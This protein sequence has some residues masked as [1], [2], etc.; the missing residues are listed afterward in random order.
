METPVKIGFA[1][2]ILIAFAIS[3]KVLRDRM[4]E[5]QGTVKIVARLDE[6]TIKEGLDVKNAIP[7]FLELPGEVGILPDSVVPPAEAA[8]AAPAAVPATP[9]SGAAAPP[10]QTSPATPGAPEPGAATSPEAAPPA[11]ASEAVAVQILPTDVK[12]ISES[13]LQKGFC[14]ASLTALV[15]QRY[16][17][18]YDSIPDS[19]LQNG[20]LKQHPE[21]KGR[22]CVFPAWITASPHTIIKYEIERAVIAMPPS[23]WIWSGGFAAVFGILLLLAY[24]RF[25][26][27]RPVPKPASKPARSSTRPRDRA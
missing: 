6:H 13:E 10:A 5:G 19:E 26:E 20:V 14:T 12:P 8:V 22:L 16:P 24:K 11:P 15:R 25:L 23:I 17:G 21:Y 4:P 2:A 7:S 3:V 27:E 18:T 9:A 1:V